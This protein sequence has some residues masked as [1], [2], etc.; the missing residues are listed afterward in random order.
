M[1]GGKRAGAGRKASLDK[2]RSVYIYIEESKI[3]AL[4][5]L[6][7]VSAIAKKAIDEAHNYALNGN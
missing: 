1:R 6:K 5:G 2:K 4:G 3:K 7:P